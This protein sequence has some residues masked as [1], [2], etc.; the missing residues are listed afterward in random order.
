MGVGRGSAE[1]G[2]G[3]GSAGKLDRRAPD[4]PVAGK[5]TL[6]MSLPPPGAEAAKP[7]QMTAGGAVARPVHSAQAHEIAAQGV[8]GA[9]RPLPHASTIQR[10]FGR[11][12]VS[13]VKAQVGGAAAVA[14]D[15]L[16]AYAYATGRSVA[17]RGEPDLHTA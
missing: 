17:F 10:L 13:N 4:H 16:G 1:R 3:A 9:S 5:Q 7:V 2:A 11:H 14:A 6:T 12:D 8:S 15:S